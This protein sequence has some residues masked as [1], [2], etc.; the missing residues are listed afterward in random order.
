LI[1]RHPHIFQ[2]EKANSP[3][4][5]EKIWLRQKGREG[6]KDSRESSLAGLPPILRLEKLV[7]RDKS[8]YI[9]K[10]MDKNIYKKLV[11]LIA[12]KENIA[13]NFG[14]I[15]VYLIIYGKIKEV[16][17]TY[18]LQKSVN[19]WEKTLKATFL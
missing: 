15:L 16:N 19:K 9:F 7:E 4:D 13:S 2:G 11:E 10:K 3:K 8:E 5:V 18:Q 6:K 12:D 1:F 14:D 17:T